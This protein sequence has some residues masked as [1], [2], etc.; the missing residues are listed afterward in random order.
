[1]SQ[2]TQSVPLRRNLAAHRLLAVSALLALLATVAV[3]L[4]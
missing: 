2:A 4:V 3:V 1:M